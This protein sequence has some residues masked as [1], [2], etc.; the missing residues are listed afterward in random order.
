MLVTTSLNFPYRFT[1]KY[2]LECHKQTHAEQCD[3]CEKNFRTISTLRDHISRV[4]TSRKEQFE[5]E[6]CKKQ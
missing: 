4:H 3:I 1:S 2:E 6:V 5:C